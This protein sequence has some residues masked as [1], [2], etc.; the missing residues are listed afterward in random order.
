MGSRAKRV[1]GPVLVVGAL[2]VTVLGTVPADRVWL[3]YSVVTVRT[4]G[5]GVGR[6][7]LSLAGGGQLVAM[8]VPA[9]GGGNFTARFVVEAGETLT[10]AWQTATDSG[11]VAIAAAELTPA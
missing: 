1:V 11:W 6:L 10:A 8:D 2:P 7:I 4:A 9:G 5:V 3:T